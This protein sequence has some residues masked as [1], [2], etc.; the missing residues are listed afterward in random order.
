VI[1]GYN[2]HATQV[3][4]VTRI[5]I[6]TKT[7]AQM[8]MLARHPGRAQI[9]VVTTQTEA[10]ARAINIS[11]ASPAANAILNVHA[12]VTKPMLVTLM[13]TA[14][15]AFAMENVTGQEEHKRFKGLAQ[16]A[17]PLLVRKIQAHLCIF[18]C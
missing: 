10:H 18:Y 6:A 15:N 13:K 14:K 9:L 8:P 3:T 2:V 16:D 17:T 1:Q 4:H 12:H 5:V 7:A 11:T